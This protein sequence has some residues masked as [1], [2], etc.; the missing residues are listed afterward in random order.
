LLALSAL[1]N[2]RLR[3]EAGVGG[4]GDTTFGLKRGSRRGN[5]AGDGDEDMMF[6]ALRLPKAGLP[7]SGDVALSSCTKGRRPGER[8]VVPDW[9][10]GVR[11]DEAAGDGFAGGVF[12]LLLLPWRSRWRRLR[13]RFGIR[14]PLL[15]LWP[16][17]EVLLDALSLLAARRC[18]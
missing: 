6:S 13:V 9:S 16:F 11:G 5:A 15:P 3:S 7:A 4:G 18:A 17:A 14:M 12:A 8:V 2:F 10:G 1:G